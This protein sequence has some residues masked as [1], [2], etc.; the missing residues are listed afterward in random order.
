MKIENF[1]K[2]NIYHLKL[3]IKKLQNI[4]KY[5]LDLLFPV[6]CLGCKKE[7]VWICEKCL[8]TI[9]INQKFLFP[10]A[11]IFFNGI[12]P[13]ISLNNLDGILVASSYHDQ[14]LNKAI[15]TF[16]YNF[17]FDLKK[18]LGNILINFLRQF[19]LS[20]KDEFLLIPVP[21]HKKRLIWRGFNQSELLTQEI[22]AFFNLEMNSEILK[23]LKNTQ[24]Q[25]ELNKKE[26]INNIKNI[27]LIS[28]YL[29]AQI[30]NK[31]IILVDDVSTT[32]S[33]LEEAGRIL[34]KA[35]FKRVWGLVLARG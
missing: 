31:K 30:L 10:Q 16:K 19:E 15:K 7:G 14:L 11:E 32:G 34:K 8:K 18:P 17:A 9:P 4:K 23:R 21:L 2:I 20:N 29:S 3:T 22:S 27:F 6:F 13:N 28:D 24:P 25:T 35:G 1:I 33:T 5:C 26:R 12:D